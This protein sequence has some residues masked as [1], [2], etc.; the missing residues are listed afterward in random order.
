MTA[1]GSAPPASRPLKVV[2]LGCYFLQ[3]EITRAGSDPREETSHTF[4]PAVGLY[5]T[6]PVPKNWNRH[7]A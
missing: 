1:Q 3:H 4:K 7:Q 6:L 2:C 5:G